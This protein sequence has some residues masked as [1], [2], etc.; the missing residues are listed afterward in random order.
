MAILNEIKKYNWDIAISLCKQDINFAKKL[1]SFINPS[2]KVF[3]YEDRQE[4]LISKSG[5][6]AFAKKN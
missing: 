1:V 6:V 2:L 4:D 3:F 5:P